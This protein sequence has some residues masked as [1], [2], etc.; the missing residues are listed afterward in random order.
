MNDSRL[1]YNIEATLFVYGTLMRGFQNPI[2]KEFLQG[3]RFLGEGSVLGRLHRVSYYPAAFPSSNSMEVIHGEIYQ[4]RD[5]NLWCLLDHYEGLD[6]VPPCEY[7]RSIT[8]LVQSNNPEL[9]RVW[10]YWYNWTLNPDH[11]I[12]S[13]RFL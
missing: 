1:N 12:P 3:S 11:H 4:I 2:R 8:S 5:P 10:I 6:Q 13:G 9:S 7:V